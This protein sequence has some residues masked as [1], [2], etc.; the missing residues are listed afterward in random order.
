MSK[1]SKRNH[2]PEYYRETADT[3]ESNIFKGLSRY[4]TY[5]FASDLVA[6]INLHKRQNHFSNTIS[7]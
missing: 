4:R 6:A 1:V 3:M 7:R 5:V 2:F